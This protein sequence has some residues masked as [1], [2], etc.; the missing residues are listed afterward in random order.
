MDAQPGPSPKDVLAA[1]L[2]ARRSYRSYRPDP[3]PDDVI[4]RLLDAA[5]RAPSAH[6]RQPWRF[7]VIRTADQKDRLADA[8][9]IRLRHDRLAD[10]D[11]AADV[12][13]DATRSVARITGA[14]VL[15]LVALSMADMDP[16]PDPR[17]NEAEHTM[18]VQSAALAAGNLLLAATAEGLGACWMCGPLFCPE[19]VAAALDLPPDWEPQALITIG[20]PQGALLDAPRRSRKAAAEAMLPGTGE[21]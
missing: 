4:D 17:R 9:A 12:E 8:M 19:V 21:P 6:N 3:V 13:G 15:V 10:G 2:D 18:A 1:L 20:R 5:C 11:A 14:P 7:A 16:Y